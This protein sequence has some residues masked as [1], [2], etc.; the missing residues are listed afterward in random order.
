MA[1]AN[2]ILVQQHGE[3][4]PQVI[5]VEGGAPLYAIEADTVAQHIGSRQAPFPCMT[6]QESLDNMAAL[7]AWRRSVGLVFDVERG[8]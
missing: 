5:V 4:E 8:E 3:A 2:Q 1:G 7:D 6:W